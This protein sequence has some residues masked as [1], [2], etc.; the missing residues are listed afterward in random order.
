M[1]PQ[2]QLALETLVGRSLTAGEITAIDPYLAA[3][4]RNDVAIAGILSIGR[5]VRNLISKSVFLRWAARTGARAAIETHALDSAS[6]LRSTALALRDFLLS[7]LTDIDFSLDEN[8][9]MLQAWVSAGAITQ[10]QANEIL[11]LATSPNPIPVGDVSDALN[12]AE[13]RMTMQD[14]QLEGPA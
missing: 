3:N 4:N 6:P 1:T 7:N 9:T 2:Q 5:T 14:F 10:T 13:G 12:K 11:S 8:V